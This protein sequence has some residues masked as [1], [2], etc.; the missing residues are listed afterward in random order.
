MLLNSSTLCFC[1]FSGSVHKNA[2]LL[3]SQIYCNSLLK[4]SI[5]KMIV[6]TLKCVWGSGVLRATFTGV[7]FYRSSEKQ[8]ERTVA[9]KKAKLNGLMDQKATAL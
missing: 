9:W 8:K 5:V 3:N 1:P 4:L 6:L 2:V 7:H